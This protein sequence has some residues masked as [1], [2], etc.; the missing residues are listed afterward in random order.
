[1]SSSPRYGASARWL[2]WL[3]AAL[4]IGMV[5]VGATMVDSVAPWQPAVVQWHKLLGLL[6]LLLVVARLVN[7]LR[8][9]PPPLPDD[10]PKL[11]AFAARGAHFALYALMFAMPLL[12][13]AMQ[14]AAGLPV[15]L[16]G[17][18]VL[19]ALVG[20][21]LAT[22]SL[23]RE[24]HALL[25]YTLFAVVLVHAGAGL[26]HGFVRRDSVLASMLPAGSPKPPIEAAPEVAEPVLSDE[27]A[28]KKPE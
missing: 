6:L 3:M 13:W 15:V 4:I 7:R 21:D 19:P 17:G 18:W 11:Q 12:G 14:G 9:P 20:A 10:V 25:A 23:L 27:E 22:Y 26:Y 2:H 28:A 24:A 16:P 1:M 8:H 5:F